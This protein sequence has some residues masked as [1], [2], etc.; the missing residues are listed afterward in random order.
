[1]HQ[2]A[3]VDQLDGVAPGLLDV[4]VGWA[5]AQ[6]DAMDLQRAK[7]AARLGGVIR[8]HGLCG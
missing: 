6:V 3:V 7:A 4:Q 8:R 2:R 5:E 1:M